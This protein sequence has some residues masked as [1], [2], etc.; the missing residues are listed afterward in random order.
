MWTDRQ[1]C[2][3]VIESPKRHVNT[4]CKQAFR[5]SI[6][7]QPVLSHT[8]IQFLTRCWL[9]LWT[10]LLLSQQ[11]TQSSFLR[12]SKNVVDLSFFSNCFGHSCSS[13]SFKYWEESKKW[14]ETCVAELFFTV[15]HLMN[16]Q[17]YLV[18]LQMVQCISQGVFYYTTTTFTF[19][20]V[21]HFADNMSVL[22]FK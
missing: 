3:P 1:R 12:S 6:V 15:N 4:W 19:R 16:T 8:A 10:W 11:I 17:I 7:R 2:P 9:T 21:V 18:T 22:L 14:I 5:D 13:E 20:N